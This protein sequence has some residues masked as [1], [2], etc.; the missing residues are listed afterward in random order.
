MVAYLYKHKLTVFI[1]MESNLLPQ[2]QQMP[3]TE[4]LKTAKTPWKALYLLPLDMALSGPPTSP[5]HQTPHLMLL[6]NQQRLA[7]ELPRRHQGTIQD[8]QLL[9]A[10]LLSHDSRA[11][12]GTTIEPHLSCHWLDQ[13]ITSLKDLRDPFRTTA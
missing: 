3:R 7:S 2:L 9:L 12:Q 6:H 11:D 4:K 8:P 5:E 10:R 13:P 1:A